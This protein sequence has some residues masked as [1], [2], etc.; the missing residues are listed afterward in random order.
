MVAIQFFLPLHLMA[1]VQA[2]AVVQMVA[3][4]QIQVVQAVAVARLAVL[5]LAGLETHHR[6]VH[7]KEITAATLMVQVATM[8]QVVAVVRLRQAA[9][10]LKVRGAG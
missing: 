8:H 4:P 3:A 7:L 6:A 9:Q 1:V 10:Q 2:V 5:K